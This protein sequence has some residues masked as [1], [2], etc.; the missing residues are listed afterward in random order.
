MSKFRNVYLYLV[1]FVSLMMI[2]IGVIVT[3][4]NLMD[5]A[6]PTYYNYAPIEK[7]TQMT[8]EEIANYEA[9]QLLAKEN[10]L[11][12]N[13]KNVAKSLIVVVVALPVFLYHWKKVQLERSE[14]LEHKKPSD[15]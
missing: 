1:S 15:S 2:L 6:F 8:P 13:K 3:V 11:V 14:L 4:Q 12:T 7:D 10:Y 9:N 5:V